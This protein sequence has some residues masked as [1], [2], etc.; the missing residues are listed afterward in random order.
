MKI[1]SINHE[2]RQMGSG[3]QCRR[4]WAVWLL[5]TTE[6]QKPKKNIIHMLISVTRGNQA[7][8]MTNIYSNET[9]IKQSNL[10]DQGERCRPDERLDQNN[11]GARN[12]S[13][14]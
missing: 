13:A 3:T 1:A 2:I 14:C 8:L 10:R 7:M 4:N 6:E 12:D 5:S 9:N 11:L